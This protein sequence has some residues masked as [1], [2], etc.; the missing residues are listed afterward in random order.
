LGFLVPTFTWYPGLREFSLTLEIASPECFVITK[1]KI[2]KALGWHR[3]TPI[4][5]TPDFRLGK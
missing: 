1:L 4:G 3:I 2:V 5:V